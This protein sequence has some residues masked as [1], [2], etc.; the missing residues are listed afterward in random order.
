ME[1]NI[2]KA[3]GAII[4][5]NGLPRGDWE[6]ATVGFIDADDAVAILALA[7]RKG[8][9]VRLIYRCE[10]GARRDMI[11]RQ[12]VYDSQQ[13]GPVANVGHAMAKDG[14]TVSFWSQGLVNERRDSGYR[15][16][17]I[18][19]ILAIKVAGVTMLTPAGKQTLGL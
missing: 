17:R 7:R 3:F 13:D 18:D 11:G 10:D 2:T 15:T 5:R 12:G 8:A 6:C 14:E 4:D 19:G 1:K 16:L 9:F